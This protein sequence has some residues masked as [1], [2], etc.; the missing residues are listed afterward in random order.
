MAWVTP[1]T[2]VTGAVI[3]AA[4]QNTNRDNLNYLKASAIVLNGTSDDVPN[5]TI[6]EFHIGTGAGTACAFVEVFV[7]GLKRRVTTDYTH[8]SGEAHVDFAW[9]PATGDAIRFNYIAA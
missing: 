3:S 7:N 4:D 2:A 8:V 1:I 5:G 6:T 9:A